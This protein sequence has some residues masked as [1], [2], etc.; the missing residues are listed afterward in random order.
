MTADPNNPG[1]F[2]YTFPNVIQVSFLFRTA[3]P[4]ASAQG[5]AGENKTGDITSVTASSC[6]VWDTT[7]SSFV[8]STDCSALN[9]ATGETEATSNKTT[10][11]VTQNP[12]TNGE[13]KVKYTNAKGGIISVYD[14]SGKAVGNYRVS[15]N[16]S[17][18]TFRT[19][20]LKAGVYILQLKSD[21]GNAVSKV[22]VK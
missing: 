2:M 12:V 7:S 8:R 17:E 1:W 5:V 11:Q 15:S 20:G 9:L 18:E 4:T 19:N 14:M 16:S 3:L 13:L 6:Y 22:I 21:S 10:L